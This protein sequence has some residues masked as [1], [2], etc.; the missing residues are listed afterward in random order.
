MVLAFVCVYSVLF[1]RFLGSNIN[2]GVNWNRT[3]TLLHNDSLIVSSTNG[4]VSSMLFF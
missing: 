3:L 2:L 1:G 4:T